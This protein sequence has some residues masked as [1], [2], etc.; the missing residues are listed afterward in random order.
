[1][2]LTFPHVLAK[3]ASVVPIN[4]LV[5]VLWAIFVAFGGYSSE[6]KEGFTIHE[7]AG[8]EE[9]ITLYNRRMFH[10]VCLF[11]MQFLLGP[12]QASSS[13]CGMGSCGPRAELGQ[14]RHFTY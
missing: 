10:R 12:L 8:L 9:N 4:T 3:R 14:V 11:R 13:W 7:R 5:V 1:M 2:I 6:S